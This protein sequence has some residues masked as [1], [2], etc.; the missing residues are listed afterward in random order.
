MP[1]IKLLIFC[2][3]G[4]QRNIRIAGI[5]RLP[6]NKVGVNRAMNLIESVF[7]T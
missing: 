4:F 6:I 7:A 2:W 1:L 5:L 3:Q